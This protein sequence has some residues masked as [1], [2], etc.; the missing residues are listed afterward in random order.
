MKVP[1]ARTSLTDTEIESVLGPLRSGWLVQGPKVR[2]FEEKWSKFTGARQSIAVTS[3]TS[4]LHLSLAALGLG[5]EDEAI[6][7]AFT[8]ISTANVVEHLGAKVVFC[9]I[10][11][12]TFNIDIQQIE[13]KITSKTKA[14][15]PVHLFGL[16]ADMPPIIELAK[17]HNLWVVEDAACGFGAKYK[18]E[19]V[20]TLGD[21]GCFSFHP[22]KAITTG[23]G[24]MVTTNDNAL[25]EKIRRLRDHGAAMTDLQRHLGARPYLLADHPDAGYNQRMTDLQGALG[26]AQM[27]RAKEIVSERQNL[28]QRYDDAFAALDWLRSPFKHANYDHGYQ[29]YPCMFMPDAANSS[30]IR[31][32]NI[33]RND[34]MDDLQKKGISTRPATHAVHML[35][36]YREKYELNPED[37][38]NAYMADQCSI[39]LPLFHGMKKE[40][41]DFVIDQVLKYQP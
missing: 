19:H 18:G 8:W 34:W 10:D 26:S 33:K 37:F 23:E 20:G 12:E 11:L 9:D 40:E 7:P 22:R 38:E 1:I 15:L 5:P 36:F 17:K 24:G 28:A 16:S 6:V 31:E 27:D 14:I 39:S 21:T 30:S 32:R 4:A 35:S 13:S 3:C 41:Q 25:A 2:E 29:S